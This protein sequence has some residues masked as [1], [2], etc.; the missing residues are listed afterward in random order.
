MAGGFARTSFGKSRIRCQKVAVIAAPKH[1]NIF[2]CSRSS[3]ITT[4]TW[5][6]LLNWQKR[7][8]SA[9][10]TEV[11]AHGNL[12]DV[13]RNSVTEENHASPK[14]R[15]AGIPVLVDT[16]PSTATVEKNAAR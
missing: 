5:K 1:M 6:L 15:T 2:S 11:K 7:T 9:R 8:T 12:T 3:R 10:L 4:A 14:C 16:V 13:L